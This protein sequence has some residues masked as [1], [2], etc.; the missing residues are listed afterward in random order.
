MKMREFF[1]RWALVATVAVAAVVG[2]CSTTRALVG[3]GKTGQSWTLSASPKV[4]AAD[5]KV[6]V[7]QGDDGNQTVDVE[8]HHLA[9]PSKVFPEAAHYVV[10]LKPEKGPAQNLGVL[11]IGEDL[12]GHLT[13]KT[14]HKSF[15]VIVTEETDMTATQPSGNLVLSASIRMAT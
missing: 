3:S 7:A 8:V 6:R 15:D 13:T 14:P 9:A 5:G 10:W 12:S 11:P 4:P 1:R 2:G